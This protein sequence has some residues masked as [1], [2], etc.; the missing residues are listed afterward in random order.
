[1]L[2][3][4]D[5]VTKLNAAADAASDA[6]DAAVAADPAGNLHAIHA[7]KMKAANAAA[8]AINKALNGDPAVAAVC[9]Q[10]DDATSDVKGKLATL[11]NIQ[12]WA[13]LLDHLA[14]LTTTAAKFLV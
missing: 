4:I 1:M 9:K 14:S 6:F 10:L 8:T 2:T 11:K 7:A 3:A 13:A 5:V 12:Q